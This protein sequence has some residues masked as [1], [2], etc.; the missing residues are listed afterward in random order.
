MLLHWQ[1]IIL[2]A[3]CFVDTKCINCNAVVFVCV[4]NFW[5]DTECINCNAGFFV[6]VFVCKTCLTDLIFF[7]IDTEHI[8]INCSGV[9]CVYV[10]L[11]NRLGISSRIWIVSTATPRYNRLGR[12]GVKNQIS[13]YQLQCCFYLWHFWTVLEFLYWY[14]TYYINCNAVSFIFLWNFSTDLEFIYN[15]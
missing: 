6:C 2:W 8:Y 1:N 4:W 3:S 14:G 15:S 9:F 5:T 12:V 11:S 13:I 10:K 7:F